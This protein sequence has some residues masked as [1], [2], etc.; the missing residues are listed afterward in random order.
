MPPALERLAPRLLD[1]LSAVLLSA[2]EEEIGELR[3][4]IRGAPRVF[5]GGMGRSGLVM[6]GFAMRLMHFGFTVHIPG[7][8][9][10][11]GIGPGDLLMLGS[12]TGRTPTLVQHTQRA[13]MQGARVALITAAPASP[14]AEEA[15]CVVRLAASVPSRTGI[16]GSGGT[17]SMLPGGSLFEMSLALLLELVVL[18]IMDEIDATPDDLLA[19]HANLE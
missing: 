7:D 13:R 9:T 2:N 4:L 8:V 10:T 6:R 16:E 11:P 14:I 3:R 15:D 19:R 18:Q 1:E 17:P 12:G 5:V